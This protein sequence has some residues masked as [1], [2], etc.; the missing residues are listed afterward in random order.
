MDRH[1]GLKWEAGE[2]PYSALYPTFAF[3][4]QNAILYAWS[5]IK[6]RWIQQFTTAPVINLQ[7]LGGSD[8]KDLPH[9]CACI[10]HNTYTKE[11]ALNNVVKLGKDFAR[12]YN[13]VEPPPPPPPPN[14]LVDE[15]YCS[16]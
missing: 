12:M 15:G 14:D 8:P 16:A 9:E 11:C 1:H 6:C 4:S 5:D 7:F 3:F 2:Y 10:H 13:M